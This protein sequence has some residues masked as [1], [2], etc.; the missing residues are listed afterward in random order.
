MMK[1]LR[2]VL[3]LSLCCSPLVFS[4]DNTGLAKELIRIYQDNLAALTNQRTQTT[5]TVIPLSVTIAS[6]VAPG[7]TMVYVSF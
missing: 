2:M 5:L 3:L 6:A 1:K 4:A 7:T